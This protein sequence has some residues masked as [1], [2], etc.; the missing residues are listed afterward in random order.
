MEAVGRRG[1]GVVCGGAMPG[2]PT[3]ISML[4]GMIPA[5]PTVASQE[6]SEQE[7]LAARSSGCFLKN[8][9]PD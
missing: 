2:L 3:T 6:G 9:Q 7:A 1:S 8:C 5:P 4:C